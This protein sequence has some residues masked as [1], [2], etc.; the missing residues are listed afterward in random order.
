MSNSFHLRPASTKDYDEIN[1]LL[2]RNYYI[3]RHL[4]WRNPLDLL[5]EQPYVIIEDEHETILALFACPPYPPGVAWVLAFA[6][7]NSIRPEQVWDLLLNYALENCAP[8][9]I[10]MLGALPTQAW[11]ARFLSSHHFNHYQDIVILEWNRK[12]PK[13][14]QPIPEG[15]LRDMKREDLPQVV[16]LDNAAF[17]PLWQLSYTSIETAFREALYATVFVQH[18]EI[19]GYQITGL[20]HLGAH[21]SRL[22]VS[23]NLRRQGLGR[24]LVHDLLSYILECGINVITVNTQDT[25]IASLALYHSLG[26]YPTGDKVPV[27]LFN[28]PT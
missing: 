3:H 27:Y 15:S 16:A 4:D 22:A 23:A 28:F 1:D 11:F 5:G 24:W 2:N 14:I 7:A 8:P 6:V 17:E 21:L 26:F 9:G 25:N 19:T 13:T 18:G 10:H 20:S 12:L